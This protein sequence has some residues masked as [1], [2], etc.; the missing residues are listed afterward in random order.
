M[1]QRFAVVMLSAEGD[2]GGVYLIDAVDAPMAEE[3]VKD[4][5]TENQDD[6]RVA[7]ILPPEDLTFEAIVPVVIR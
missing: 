7:P 1:S 3:M 6:Q 5:I 4:F 2:V